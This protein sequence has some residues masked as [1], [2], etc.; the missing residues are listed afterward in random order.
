M[1]EAIDLG[2]PAPEPPGGEAQ[3]V[4]LCEA[5]ALY[6]IIFIKIFIYEVVPKLQFWNNLIRFK[7]KSGL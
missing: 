3:A 6:P 2:K 5:W 7:W 4:L 1:S